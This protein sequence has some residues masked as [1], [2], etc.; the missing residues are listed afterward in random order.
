MKFELDEN[1][2]SILYEHD[3][4]IW[5]CNMKDCSSN[6]G[7]NIESIRNLEREKRKWVHWFRC[8]LLASSIIDIIVDHYLPYE[9]L[10]V[11]LG[12]VSWKTAS[13]FGFVSWKTSSESQFSSSWV[14]SIS[15]DISLVGVSSSRKIHSDALSNWDNLAIKSYDHREY[16]RKKSLATKFVLSRIRWLFRAS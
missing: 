6:D 1:I 16:G 4:G 14:S 12:F 10:R 8:R 11:I 9:C 5:K 7:R 2:H 3:D 15:W 13:C